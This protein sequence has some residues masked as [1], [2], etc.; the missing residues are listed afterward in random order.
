MTQLRFDPLVDGILIG[1]AMGGGASLIHTIA[2]IEPSPFSV[3]I[4]MGLMAFVLI[5]AFLLL[6]PVNRPRELCTRAAREHSQ[7]LERFRCFYCEHLDFTTKVLNNGWSN[8]APTCQKC[9]DE[10]T[11]WLTQHGFPID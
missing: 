10:Q 1:T 4:I 8:T 7:W 2:G 9:R 3:G 6:S 5:P 11:G